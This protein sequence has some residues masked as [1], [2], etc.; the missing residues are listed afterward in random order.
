[1]NLL[2]LLILLGGC[3]VSV[4]LAGGPRQG[5][6][7]VFLL[8]AGVVLI[9]FRPAR[10]TSWWLWLGGLL[11]LLFCSVSLLPSGYLPT[12]EWKQA[13]GALPAITLPPTITCDPYAAGFWLAV[14]AVSIATALFV[15]GQPMQGGALRILALVAVLGCTAYAVTAMA[16]WNGG[17]HYPFFKQDPLFPAAFGFFTNRNQTAGFLLTGAILSLA[18]I[19]RGF[20]G[21]RWFYVLA[22][23]AAFTVL[24]YCLLFLSASRGGLVF[25]VVGCVV[26]IAGL[27]GYRSKSLLV[28]SILLAIIIGLAFVRS[29]SALVGRLLGGTQ[30]SEKTVAESAQETEGRPSD[31]R[32]SIW[33]DTLT[34]IREQPL[35]GSGLGSYA[36]SYPFHAKRSFSQATALHAESSWLTLAAEAGIPA[37]LAVLGCLAFLIAGIPRLERLSGRDWPLRWGFLA[38]FFAEL[39]HG[40]VDVPLHKP[41][42]GWWL[43]LLGGIGF[44][45]LVETAIPD[46]LKIGAWLQRIV[47]ILA[48]LG[49][50]LLGGWMLAAQFGKAPALPPFAAVDSEKHIESLYRDVPDFSPEEVSSVIRGEMVR[51]PMN[52]RLHFLLGR[53]LLMTPGGLEMAKAEFQAQQTLSPNDPL[54]PKAEGTEIAPYDTEAAV[55]YWK[56]AIRRRIKIDE[57]IHWTVVDA[58]FGSMISD[59]KE[60]PELARRLDEIAAAS[61]RLRFELLVR[62]GGDPALIPSAANDEPF[63]QGLTSKQRQRLFDLWYERGDRASLGSWLAAHPAYDWETLPI[64]ALI[65]TD[66]PESRQGYDLLMTAF[67]IPMPEAEGDSVIRPTAESVPSDPAEAAGYYLRQGNIVTARRLLSQP[68]V[69]GKAEGQRLR[70]ALDAREGKWRDAVQ[71]LLSYLHQTQKL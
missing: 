2:S 64:R 34:M 17:W 69:L 54:F 12:P 38:A 36:Y 71:H 22:G 42:L 27:G 57:A 9:V 63:M 60:Y 47:L 28:M 6:E 14:L 35:A 67:S 29:D 43:L 58:T 66:G 50:F 70:A 68:E 44:A 1:M 48:G 32:I 61:P 56:E 25:L 37:L 11:V 45:P 19:R 5:G 8:S 23:V 30:R 62:K 31:A 51:Q 13:L 59:A 26:W 3:L 53:M 39:L 55:A 65:L 18:M 15:L 52:P 4:F 41:E 10:S 40:L 46:R 7:G 24:C 49:S 21:Q 16:V 20:I 33:K